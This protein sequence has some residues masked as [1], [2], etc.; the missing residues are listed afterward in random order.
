[1]TVAT[2]YDY[3]IEIAGWSGPSYLAARPLSYNSNGYDP[4]LT[5]LGDVTQSVEP[6]RRSSCRF[7]VSNEP[8]GSSGARFS[9]YFSASKIEG[10]SVT[11]REVFREGG[12]SRTLFVGVVRSRSYTQDEVEVEVIGSELARSKRLDM[13]VSEADWTRA[14]PADIGQSIPVVFNDVPDLVG[15][16]VAWNAHSR[17]A[18]ELDS[19]ST[20]PIELDSVEGF[21]SS[22]TIR[23]DREKISF[24]GITNNTLTGVTRG[25]SSTTAA[26]HIEG[27]LVIMVNTFD[28]GIDATTEGATVTK[29]EAV[30]SERR[31][32]PL[33]DPDSIEEVGGATLARWDETPTYQEPAGELDAHSIELDQDGGSNCLYHER[34]RAR[35]GSYSDSN[36]CEVHKFSGT[37]EAW[38]GYSSVDHATRGRVKKILLQVVHSG[39][40]DQLVVDGGKSNLGTGTANEVKAET[41]TGSPRQLVGYLAPVDQ[42]DPE[43]LEIAERKGSRA[44]QVGSNTTSVTAVVVKPNTVTEDTYIASY[45][46]Q[47]GSRN[48]MIDGDYSNSIL[49]GAG[50]ARRGG[51][52]TSTSPPCLLGSIRPRCPTRSCPSGATVDRLRSAPTTPRSP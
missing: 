44:T 24:T 5:E 38:I 48:D 21:P 51:A 31:R 16:V 29:A 14:K 30:D 41:Q 28:I 37:H 18:A 33:P 46:V 45:G 52:T 43:F 40:N 1:M 50:A 42:L 34:A 25:A 10:R 26:A 27:S 35:D 19:S 6:G 3:L 49:I 7:T 2:A 9:S 8:Y 17:L 15:P 20:D 12:S 32:W 23:I 36:Y 4:L 11:I 22:G 39:N 47:T 13:M